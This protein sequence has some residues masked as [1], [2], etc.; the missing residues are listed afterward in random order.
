M[1]GQERFET[2]V[3]NALANHHQEIEEL[4]RYQNEAAKIIHE[5]DKRAFS[6]DMVLASFVL[7]FALLL[8]VAVWR[9]T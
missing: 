7:I 8:L 4:F 9:V 1:D 3:R 6:R 5:N 2:V